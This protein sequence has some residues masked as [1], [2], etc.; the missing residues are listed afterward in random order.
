MKTVV[1]ENKSI[2]IRQKMKSAFSKVLLAARARGSAKEKTQLALAALSEIAFLDGFEQP[3]ESSGLEAQASLVT[4]ALV[5]LSPACVRGAV[6]GLPQ[7]V[8][9]PDLRTAEVFRAALAESVKHRASD[10]LVKIVVADH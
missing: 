9:V 2:V 3:A 8:T 6:T 5:R 7:I 10:R 4:L 1:S